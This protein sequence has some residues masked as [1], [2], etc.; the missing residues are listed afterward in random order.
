MD[1]PSEGCSDRKLFRSFRLRLQR[2][3]RPPPP[4]LLPLLK[5]CYPTLSD[6]TLGSLRSAPHECEENTANTSGSR[7]GNEPRRRQLSSRLFSWS[8]CNLRKQLRSR[9]GN[10]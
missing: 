8:R 7:D 6:C 1:A 5:G 9:D 2:A 3:P 4:A 10:E